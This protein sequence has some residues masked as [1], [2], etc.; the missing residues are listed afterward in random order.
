MIPYAKGVCGLAARTKQTQLVPDVDQFPGHI[1]CDSRS[2]SELVIPVVKNSELF[3][4][5]DLDS[6]SVNRFTQDDA[7]FFEEIVRILLSKQNI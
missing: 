7:T 4:V 3:A 1:V 5:L 2:R 6:A